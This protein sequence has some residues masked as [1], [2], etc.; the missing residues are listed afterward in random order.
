MIRIPG[1]AAL[2]LV[3]ATTATAQQN[4]K[5]FSGDPTRLPGVMRELQDLT[6]GLV[7][8]LSPTRNA[9]ALELK[10]MRAQLI[11]V[12]EVLKQ[13]PFYAKPVG[14]SSGPRIAWHPGSA[15]WR[16]ERTW[17]VEGRAEV[18]SFLNFID[19]HGNLRIASGPLRGDDQESHGLRVT[20]NDLGCPFR[21]QDPLF[22]DSLGPVF[23]APDAVDEQGFPRFRNCIVVTQRHEPLF[24]P[25]SRERV[26]RNYLKDAGAG[27]KEIEDMQRAVPAE[28]KKEYEPAVTERR[29]RYEKFRGM[30]AAM[31]PA[32][33]ASPAVINGNLETVFFHEG[34]DA[35]IAVV[36]PNPKFFDP[37]R[38]DQIQVLDVLIG[39]SDEERHYLPQVDWKALLALAR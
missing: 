18:A 11:G 35:R 7:V 19:Q 31:S 36:E 8:E 15:N 9:T 16:G 22:E 2:C 28:R 38:L 17:P 33:R 6:P 27:L 1:A 34:D 14:F 25:V 23:R 20:A 26:L 21:R 13:T 3:A 24:I 30:L 5:P 39:L 37:A 32:E 29:A 4:G 10:S 12:V